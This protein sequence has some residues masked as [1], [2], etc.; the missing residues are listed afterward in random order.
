MVGY[1]EEEDAEEAEAFAAVEHQLDE[2]EGRTQHML[3]IQMQMR[4]H[5]QC[6]K[7]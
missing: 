5:N 3:H 6:S 1:Q 2:D 4:A 7:D